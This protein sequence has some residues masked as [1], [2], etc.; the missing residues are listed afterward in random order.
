V[1]RD[2]LHDHAADADRLELADRRKRAGAADL[3]LDIPQH[4]HGALGRELMRDGPARR[5]RDEAEPFLPVDPVDLVHDAVDVIV[6]MRAPGFDLAMKTKQFFHRVAK[7]GERIGREA[8]PLEPFDHAGLRIG[9]HRGHLAPGIGEEAQRTRGGDPGVLLAQRAGRRI[10]W[11]DEDVVAGRF[12]PL[13]QRQK[14]LL[15][16]IDFAAHL[17]NVG[18][19]TAPKFL[20]HVLKRSDVGGD[21]FAHRAVATRGGGDEFAALV[22]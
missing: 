18:H 12:L 11:V 15:G 14:P 8:A 4:G 21:V 5:A 16:H 2:V 3:D 1:Q 20:R 17:A 10:A 7:P 9:R 6:E 22:A 19:V 13:V